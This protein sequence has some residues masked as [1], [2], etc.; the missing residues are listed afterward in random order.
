MIEGMTEEPRSRWTELNN[1]KA[2][3]VLAMSHNMAP[4]KA[5]VAKMLDAEI[6]KI[7]IEIDALLRALGIK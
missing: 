1:R 6:E 5:D 4:E 7:D 2:E 3:L